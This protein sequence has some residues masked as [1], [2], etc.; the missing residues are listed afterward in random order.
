MLSDLNCRDLLNDFWL[1]GLAAALRRTRCY[2][3]ILHRASVWRRP[4]DEGGDGDDDNNELG[5]LVV[6]MWDGSQFFDFRVRSTGIPAFLGRLLGKYFGHLWW[7]ISVVACA[8]VGCTFRLWSILSLRLPSGISRRRLRA[9]EGQVDGWCQV[10][11][12]AR[13]Q[14]RG[15]FVGWQVAK[16]GICD[17]WYM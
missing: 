15:T 7:F 8:F 10:K 6:V 2:V 1:F 4:T 16:H 3:S 12:C 9:W 14:N 11:V 13:N 17:L 5:L